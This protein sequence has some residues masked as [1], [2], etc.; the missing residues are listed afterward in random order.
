MY[1]FNAED[2][3]TNVIFRSKVI[4]VEIILN[5]GETKEE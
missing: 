3:G 2:F 5:V 1:Y 4:I